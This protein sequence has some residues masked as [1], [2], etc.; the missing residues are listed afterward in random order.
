MS[1]DDPAARDLPEVLTADLDR[2]TVEQLFDDLRDCAVVVEVLLKHDP[3]ALVG[4]SSVDL[5]AGRVA[6]DDPEVRAVQIRY[7]AL[8]RPW[9]DTLL[10]T[11]GG[12]RLVRMAAPE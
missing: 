2:A 6:L 3:R 7:R 12:F 9:I 1:A 4:E 10:R 11:P 5:A 8:D